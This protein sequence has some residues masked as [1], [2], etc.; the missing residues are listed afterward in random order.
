MFDGAVFLDVGAH[1]GQTLEEVTRPKYAF[2]TIYS[3]EPMPIQFNHL[4][5]A[6]RSYDNVQLCDYGLGD[7]TRTTT[8]YGANEH[9]ESSIY[10]DKTDVASIMQTECVIVDASNWFSRN[11]TSDD[12]VIMKINTEGSEIPIM[13]SL[14]ESKEIFKIHNVML[15]FDCR[16]VPSMAHHETLLLERLAEIGFT[17]FSLCDNVMRGATHQKRIENWLS[18]IDV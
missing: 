17:R 15:D 4:V 9:C 18:T 16:R 7:S 2:R 14:I 6:F 11:L 12:T 1:V 5:R 10:A 3:F 13:Y 8:L